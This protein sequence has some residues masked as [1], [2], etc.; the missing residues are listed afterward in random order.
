M[1]SHGELALEAHQLAAL[2]P[3]GFV[4]CSLHRNGDS[5]ILELGKQIPITNGWECRPLSLASD[6]HWSPGSHSP[7]PFHQ[8]PLFLLLSVMLHSAVLHVIPW[9]SRPGLSPGLCMHCPVAWAC[10]AWHLSSK[11]LNRGLV[12]TSRPLW[13]WAQGRPVPTVCPRAP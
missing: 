12:S 6:T 11:I 9:R 2:T 13:L 7:Y 5:K 8:A 10:A 4:T 3:P 1:S